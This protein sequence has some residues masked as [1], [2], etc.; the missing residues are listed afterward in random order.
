MS[1]KSAEILRAREGARRKF[2]WD[3]HFCLRAD[4]GS[5]AARARTEPGCPGP[6][7][8]MNGAK[9]AGEALT[10]PWFCTRRKPAPFALK[11]SDWGGAERR[12]IGVKMLG[13]YFAK[14]L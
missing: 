12:P 13:N 10:R 2:L 9:G 1:K 3:L 5:S 8:G 14:G 11:G 6:S 4:G 7:R